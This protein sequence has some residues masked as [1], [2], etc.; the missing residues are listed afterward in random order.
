MNSEILLTDVS[1]CLP[2]RCYFGIDVDQYPNY[3]IVCNYNSFTGAGVV[4]YDSKNSRNHQ[5][6]LNL[7]GTYTHILPATYGLLRYAVFHS[8]CVS[9]YSKF[10]GINTSIKVGM[11][12]SYMLKFNYANGGDDVLWSNRCIS[13]IIMNREESWSQSPKLWDNMISKNICKLHLLY[14]DFKTLCSDH[15]QSADAAVASSAATRPSKPSSDDCKL[16]ICWD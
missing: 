5:L 16:L 10:P 13:V 1:L 2:K 15:N 14:Q 12:V 3:G 6:H 11:P 9:Y 7:D 4:C 8:S